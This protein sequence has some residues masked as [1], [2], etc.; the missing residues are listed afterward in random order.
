MLI[1]FFVDVRF[2]WFNYVILFI[3]QLFSSFLLRKSVFVCTVGTTQKTVFLDIF[4]NYY[5]THKIHDM[6]ADNK[7]ITTDLN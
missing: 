2:Y 6:L 3:M 1:L 7:I 5:L 4:N